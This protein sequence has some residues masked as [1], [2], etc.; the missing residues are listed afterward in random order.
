[1]KTFVNRGHEPLNN[2]QFQEIPEI[3]DLLGLVGL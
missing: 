3:G 1:M 2:L